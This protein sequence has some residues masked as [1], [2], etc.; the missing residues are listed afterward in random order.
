MGQY[1][2][3]SGPGAGEKQIILHAVKEKRLSEKHQFH[4]YE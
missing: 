1:L 2:A 3:T 4:H